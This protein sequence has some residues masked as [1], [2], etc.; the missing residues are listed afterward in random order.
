M[1]KIILDE[2]HNLF[3]Y[4]TLGYQTYYNPQIEIDLME[5]LFFDSAKVACV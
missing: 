1:G 5:K 4:A 2:P 3:N